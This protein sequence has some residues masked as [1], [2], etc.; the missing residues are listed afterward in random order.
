[1]R[2][3]S[4][5]P[6][7]LTIEVSYTYSGDYGDNGILIEC[8]A[9]SG[10]NEK[11]HASARVPA[12]TGDHV[13]QMTLKMDSIE[14]S[15]YRTDELLFSLYRQPDD[16]L[17][18]KNWGGIRSKRHGLLALNKRMDANRICRATKIRGR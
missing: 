13:V 16:F 15:Q 9:M 7:T 18:I 6:S 3:L 8:F 12:S 11:Q 4:E 5:T 10:S 2:K 17:H 14:S 1:V